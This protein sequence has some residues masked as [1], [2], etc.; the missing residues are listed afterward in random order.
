MDKLTKIESLSQDKL[1]EVWVEILKKEK[2]SGISV[3]VN[4]ITA[5]SDSILV[6]VKCLYITFPFQLSGNIDVAYIAREITKLR[7]EEN[8]NLV[9][10]VS[11]WHISNG[12]QRTIREII[13][14]FEISFIGRDEL[15]K[16]VDQHFPDLWKHEDV[17]LLNYENEFKKSV[18]NDNQLRKLKLP[19]EKCQRLLDIYISPRITSYEEDSKTKTF[20]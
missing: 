7:N 20:K 4:C 9:T 16:L 15:V 18:S 13:T 6:L 8:A 10:I 12:F 1:Q 3:K 5:N 19:S 2:F 11:Q 17:E 14:N